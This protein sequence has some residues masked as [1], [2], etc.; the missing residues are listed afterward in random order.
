MCACGKDSPTDGLGRVCVRYGEG[1]GG[2]DVSVCGVFALVVERY[3]MLDMTCICRANTRAIFDDATYLHYL[4]ARCSCD[5]GIVRARVAVPTHLFFSL[6]ALR[7]CGEEIGAGP[8]R[9]DTHRHCRVMGVKA[10]WTKKKR[11]VHEIDRELWEKAAS[12]SGLQQMQ[13]HELK[14]SSAC[15]C[16]AFLV[17][18]RL[19][20]AL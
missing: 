16:V 2:T 18:S 15:K 5:S 12:G 1:A 6:P 17:E 20:I 13:L 8:Q 11:Q 14:H 4:E 9:M 3:G 10:G 19:R 7:G